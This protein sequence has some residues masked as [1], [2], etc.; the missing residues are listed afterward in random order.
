MRGIADAGFLVALGNR[1]DKH[2]AWAVE[3]ARGVTEPL[4]TSEAVLAERRF[5]CAIPA[6]SWPSLRTAWFGPRLP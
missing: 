1:R 2:L 6:W 4:L 5:T 3:V